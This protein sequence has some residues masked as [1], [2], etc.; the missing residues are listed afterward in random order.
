MTTLLTVEP[1][2]VYKIILVGSVVHI[3]ILPL[4]TNNDAVHHLSN[5]NFLQRYSSIFSAELQVQLVLK[6]SLYLHGSEYLGENNTMRTDTGDYSKI[7]TQSQ[8][9]ETTV[10]RTSNYV[11]KQLLRRSRI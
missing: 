2:L 3:I 4:D 10:D 6:N 8:R 9:P 5:E 11:P 7:D 1:Y